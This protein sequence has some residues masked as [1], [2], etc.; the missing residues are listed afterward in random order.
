MAPT[1]VDNLD[2]W[3]KQDQDCI[4]LPLFFIEAIRLSR[5]NCIFEDRPLDI[6]PLC[7]KIQ[8]QVLSFPVA[9]P[10]RKPRDF[11]K[12]PDI[13]YPSSFFDGAAASKIGGAG[14]TLSINQSHFFLIK[15]GCGTSTNTRTE[16]LAFWALMFF[17][18]TIGLPVL[19][20][21]GDSSVIINRANS[22][23]ALAALDLDYWYDGIVEIK[24]F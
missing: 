13:N 14:I 11:G 21:C 15:M 4:H 19:H 7:N 16:L 1:L 22:E 24:V 9:H 3:F 18:A 10:K 8:D 20:V 17:A 2:S 5:N 23:A 12:A 6:V